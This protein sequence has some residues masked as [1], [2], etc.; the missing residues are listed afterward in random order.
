VRRTLPPSAEIENQIDELLAV[1]VGEN[2]RQSLSELAKLGA[3]L[4]I[5]RAV[6]DEFESRIGLR[7]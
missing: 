7:C 5:Q 2:P 3:R 4:I 1:G 6:E